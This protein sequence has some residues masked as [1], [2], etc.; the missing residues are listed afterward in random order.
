[1]TQVLELTVP[2]EL[3]RRA[4]TEAIRSSRSMQEVIVDWLRAGSDD[5]NDLSDSQLLMVCDGL[6]NSLDQQ[7]LSE[8]LD[9]NREGLLDAS[10]RARLQLLM[11]S[12]QNGLARKARAWRMAVARGLRTSLD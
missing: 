6:M 7:E 5:L 10:G 9:Q 8:L 2:D 4:E 3:A 12:Y 11:S 1:M